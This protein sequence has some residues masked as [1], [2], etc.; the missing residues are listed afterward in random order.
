MIKHEGYNMKQSIPKGTK[1]VIDGKEV[2]YTGLI[3]YDAQGPYHVFEDGD[4]YYP[5]RIRQ[6]R[7]LEIINPPDIVSSTS[8]TS[9]LAYSQHILQ[10][11][12]KAALEEI[13]EYFRERGNLTG[14]DEGDD[15]SR[16]Y[17]ATYI[18]NDGIAQS[19]YYRE[20]EVSDDNRLYIGLSDGHWIY[21]EDITANN[22]LDI[23]NIIH[24][25]HDTY[26][27]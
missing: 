5:N 24:E 1:V 21:Q 6:D 19:A 17:T 27:K 8:Q 22:I 4:N 15:D 14:L 26:S 23:I 13:R 2:T 9:P 25:N 20:I 18:D 10:H 16:K 3:G 7:F 12:I 11:Q